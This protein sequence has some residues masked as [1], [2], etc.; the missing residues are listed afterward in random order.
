MDASGWVLIP[1]F[2]KALGGQTTDESIREVVENDEKGRFQVH[3]FFWCCNLGGW[4][5]GTFRDENALS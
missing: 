5:R 3:Q 2:K 4:T 1:D